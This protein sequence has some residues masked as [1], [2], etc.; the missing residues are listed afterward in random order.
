MRAS[1]GYVCAVTAPGY[2]FFKD[3]NKA[4]AFQ[5]IDDCFINELAQVEIP[6]VNIWS[7]IFTITMD[8]Q[9][10]CAAQFSQVSLHAISR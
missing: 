1:S 4:F 7:V 5:F 10:C 3:S 6:L 9:D 2:F 8:C